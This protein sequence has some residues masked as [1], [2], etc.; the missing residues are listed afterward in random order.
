M[1]I[2][3]QDDRQGVARVPNPGGQV[4][5][6]GVVELSVLV[7]TPAGTEPERRRITAAI[8]Q[9]NAQ[10]TWRYLTRY[11]PRA[12]ETAVG[13]RDTLPRVGSAPRTER[14]GVVVALVRGD[15]P[16]VLARVSRADIERWQATGPWLVIIE[17][18]HPVPAPDA[19]TLR[20]R[21]NQRSLIDWAEVQPRV[22]VAHRSP[23][24]DISS[25]VSHLLA[26][27]ARR[28]WME[29]NGV[30]RL[31]CR[32]CGHQ[33]AFERST[34][35]CPRDGSVMVQPAVIH[36][37][38][39]P[40]WI[41]EFPVHGV[42]G[43]GAFGK[44]WLSM[45]GRRRWGALK[46]LVD[47]ENAH[48][49][50]RLNR[51]LRL[52]E[53]FD[54]PNIVKLL[55]RGEVDGAPVG[56]LEFLPGRPLKFVLDALGPRHVLDLTLELLSAL[57]AIHQAGIVHRDLKPGNIMLVDDPLRPAD[58]PRLVLLD[59]GLGKHEMHYQEQLTKQGMVLG[60]PSYMAP[61]QFTSAANVDCRADIYA[62]GVMLYM[63]LTP[64]K[65]YPIAPPGNM[66][67]VVALLD[68]IRRVQTTDPDPIERPDLPLGIRQI[69]LQALARDPARRFASAG[70]MYQALLLELER[71]DD[72]T[73]D[74]S[75]H[76]WLTWSPSAAYVAYHAQA[77][78]SV[79]SD[80][81]VSS[82]SLPV[83]LNSNPAGLVPRPPPPPVAPSPTPPPPPPSSGR[84][85]NTAVLSRA[86][87]RADGQRPADGAGH[88]HGPFATGGGEQPDA[89]SAQR[90]PGAPTPP[91]EAQARRQTVVD[92]RHGRGGVDY[93]IQAAVPAGRSRRMW[94]V[95]LG[96]ALVL[97]SIAGGLW[98]AMSPTPGFLAVTVLGQDGSS[99]SDV[100]VLVDG[101]PADVITRGADRAEIRLGPVDDGPWSISVEPP[102]GLV[103]RGAA[104]ATLRAEDLDATHR[105]TLV[106]ELFNPFAILNP[107]GSLIPVSV[108]DDHVV[109]QRKVRMGLLVPADRAG[110]LELPGGLRLF[111]CQGG[112]IIEPGTGEPDPQTLRGYLEACIAAADEDGLV[113]LR[114]G[115]PGE[116]ETSEIR[117]RVAR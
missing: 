71:W 21:N 1:D 65:R 109:L 107:G 36:K 87:V 96:G 33:V 102:P 56:L 73:I 57:M 17:D 5:A 108:A 64:D 76:S 35:R 9:L 23:G 105:A 47:S 117:A 59:F 113:V 15:P 29:R 44:V 19:R 25:V 43:R 46:T 70:Q 39:V 68:F 8:E 3:P 20:V 18:L 61:E 7:S 41:G 77:R 31:I 67:D 94:P 26:D 63:A 110:L 79:S 27:V 100:P 49:L 69:V 104:E 78:S 97:A 2:R 6:N 92:P 62:V 50:A 82:E 40:G 42:V 93:T 75:D 101:Q 115:L 106:F 98:W 54:H 11:S 14:F 89:A 103:V 48:A 88:L 80:V 95:L 91:V 90:S 112:S 16:P 53:Q 30:D 86:S 99:M 85:G 28:G 66:S 45:D 13:L 51:E 83:T 60:T 55:E 81:T 52:L 12:D 34:G 32:Q 116:R 72:M 37:R 4:P 58:A 84:S 114:V 111:G 38:R 74:E 22:L 10:A 24:D